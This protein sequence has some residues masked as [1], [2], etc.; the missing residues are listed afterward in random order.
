MLPAAR[1]LADAHAIVV[2]LTSRERMPLGGPT[3]SWARIRASGPASKCSTTARPRRRA[4]RLALDRHQHGI[5]P[6]RARLG[7]GQLVARISAAGAQRRHR[8][9]LPGAIA[10]AEMWPRFVQQAGVH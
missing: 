10:D 1:S 6:L 3:P 5:H 7:A 2:E 8:R 9:V 4:L